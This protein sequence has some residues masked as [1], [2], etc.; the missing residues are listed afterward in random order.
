M[1][2]IK[3]EKNFV[4]VDALTASNETLTSDLSAA[5]EKVTELEAKLAEANTKLGQKPAA[6]AEEIKAEQDRI[7]KEGQ[8][9]DIDL[10]MSNE[11]KE[12]Y[13]L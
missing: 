9:E 6:T 10:K 3:E 8:E 7:A 1:K 2:K 12:K 11:L 4:N 5:N 13:G